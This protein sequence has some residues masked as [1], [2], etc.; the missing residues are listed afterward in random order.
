[1]FR[2][3]IKKL[4]D[5]YGSLGLT[6]PFLI[7]FYRH[8][9]ESRVTETVDA[10]GPLIKRNLCSKTP[11]RTFITNFGCCVYVSLCPFSSV[12]ISNAP[13]LPQT[14]P[15]YDP[16][17]FHLCGRPSMGP[18][19]SYPSSSRPWQSRDTPRFRARSSQRQSLGFGHVTATFAPTDTS[20][21]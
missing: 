8:S 6:S 20:D 18:T 19:L 1:M 15:S 21:W 16:R 4:T 9:L 5:E 13:G 10:T 3:S 12:V 11:N 17:P 2:D 7:L 14:P